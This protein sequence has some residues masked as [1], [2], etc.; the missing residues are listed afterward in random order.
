MLLWTSWKIIRVP[1][2]PYPNK[3]IF[4]WTYS[5]LPTQRKRRPWWDYS[6]LQM[7]RRVFFWKDWVYFNLIWLHTQTNPTLDTLGGCTP[8]FSKRKKRKPARKMPSNTT[9][10]SS[11]PSIPLCPWSCQVWRNS[12]QQLWKDQGTVSWCCHWALLHSQCHAPHSDQPWMDWWC[13]DQKG[14]YQYLQLFH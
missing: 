4:V 11:E 8:S 10:W 6:H 14:I 2:N 3:E 13:H 9:C 5:S 7:K 12:L 1:Q